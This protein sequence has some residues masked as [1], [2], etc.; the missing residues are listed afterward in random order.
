MEEKNCARSNVMQYFVIDHKIQWLALVLDFFRKEE[1]SIFYSRFI[2]LF[3]R[4]FFENGE[5]IG[6]GLTVV[7]IFGVDHYFLARASNRIN[8]LLLHWERNLELLV[9]R[10]E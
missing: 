3:I 1:D 9:V 2:S 4:A 10:Y 8:R 6:L 5:K 7:E